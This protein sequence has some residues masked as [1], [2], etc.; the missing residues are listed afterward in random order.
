MRTHQSH[1]TLN[2]Y[3]DPT[4]SMEEEGQVLDIGGA[5]MWILGNGRKTG[6]TKYYSRGKQIIIVGRGIGV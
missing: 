4:R 1:K 2:R 5:H 6:D 3:G